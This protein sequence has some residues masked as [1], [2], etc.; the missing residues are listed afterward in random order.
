V[1]SRVKASVDVAATDDEQS[2]VQYGVWCVGPM[3]WADGGT[4][5]HRV[6]NLRSAFL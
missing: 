4:M 5:D 1:D 2:G 3:R 6:T